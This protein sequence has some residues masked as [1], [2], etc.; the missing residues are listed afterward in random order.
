LGAAVVEAVL[1]LH[2]FRNDFPRREIPGLRLVSCGHLREAPWSILQFKGENE[3]AFSPLFLDKEGV[4]H[5]AQSR[6]QAGIRV[7][8]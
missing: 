1:F 8:Q 6:V 3:A 5:F 2:S 7:R 4:Q